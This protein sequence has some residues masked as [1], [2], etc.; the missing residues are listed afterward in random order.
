MAVD[1]VDPA[2]KA[3]VLV[4]GGLDSCVTAAIARQQHRDILFLH[5]NYGQRTEAREKK[6]FHDLAD[7]WQVRDRLDV[8]IDPLR[9]VGGSSLTDPGI[10]VTE[11]DL[12]AVEIPSSYVPFRN[13]HL[14]AAATSWAEA[15]GAGR[16]YIG[17]VEEDSSGYPD[18][19]PAF[20][21]AFNTVI[22]LGTRPETGIRIVTP[23]I[24]L[25]KRDIVRRGIE[26]N[27][28]FHLTW[29]CYR[30]EESACGT[31]DSC[32]LRLRG[33]QQAGVEDPLPYDSRPE[34]VGNDE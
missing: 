15:A 34:Y 4:S 19:R 29:S 22:E 5:V 6:A 16:I 30:N 7:F 26:L 20:Y 32:A 31:C 8:V 11:A 12:S 23:I 1:V 9:R 18:C 25:S 14:L 28:P 13:A 3:V 33:F 10:E 24:E 27:A 21:D 17:A 2:G